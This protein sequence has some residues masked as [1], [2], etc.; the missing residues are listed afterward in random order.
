MSVV[1]IAFCLSA[2]RLTSQRLRVPLN[3]QPPQRAA[4]ATA[5]GM[6]HAEVTAPHVRL[7]DGLAIKEQCECVGCEGGDVGGGAWC[8]QLCEGVARHS[9]IDC[10]RRGRHSDVAADRRYRAREVRET[11]CAQWPRLHL[12]CA[13]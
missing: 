5:D 10:P 6:R 12:G 1:L 4:R 3:T 2:R 8:A 7:I 9:H 11:A 13:L